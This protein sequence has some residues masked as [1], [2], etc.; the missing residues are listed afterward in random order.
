MLCIGFWCPGEARRF[1]EKLILS[2]VY[3]Y[4]IQKSG[5]KSGP[6]PIEGVSFSGKHAS[7]PTLKAL[8]FRQVP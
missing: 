6:Y 5:P 1:L 2:V 8:M 4:T 3:F 7:H